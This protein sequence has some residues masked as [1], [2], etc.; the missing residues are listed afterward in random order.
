MSYHR[1]MTNTQR[2]R[3][4]VHAEKILSHIPDAKIPLFTA[5][6]IV[7][8]PTR[9]LERMEERGK[10][11]SRRLITVSGRPGERR[12]SLHDALRLLWS[13]PEERHE[14]V[15]RSTDINPDELGKVITAA[16]A[17]QLLGIARG[18]LHKWEAAGRLSPKGFKLDRQTVYDRAEV[19]AILEKRVS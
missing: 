15:L 19:E 14:K 16:E 2:P 10:I 6:E 3:S 17:A 1:D 5:A 7:G 8:V 4:E 13:D 9:T 18:T 12:Y 11:T